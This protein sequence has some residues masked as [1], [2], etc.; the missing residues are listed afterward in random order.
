MYISPIATMPIAQALMRSERC[1]SFE[2]NTERLLH[3]LK[4][5]NV[6]LPQFVCRAA[7]RILEFVGEEEGTH[8][9][10]RGARVAYQLSTLVVRQYEQAKDATLKK[11]CLDLIDEME[12]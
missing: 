2:I 10:S 8:V 4:E 5:S 1:R 9:T 7:E 3:S 6:E 12:Q 11:R